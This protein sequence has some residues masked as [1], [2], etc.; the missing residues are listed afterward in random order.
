MQRY[1]LSMVM[2]VGIVLVLAVAILANLGSSQSRAQADDGALLQ[3]PDFPPTPTVPAAPSDNPSLQGASIFSDAFVADGA[4]PAGWQVIDL[5]Q[6]MPGEESV[7]RVAGGRLIQDRTARASNPASRITLAV[8][9]DANLSDYTVSAKAFDLANAT[10]GL[11]ARA[12]GQSFYQFAWYAKDVSE[13]KKLVLEKV[14]DGNSTILAIADGP[15][16]EHRTW[17]TLGLQVSGSSIRALIDGKVV[18]EATD[19]S[20]TN[21]QFGVSTVAFGAVTF[22]NVVVTVP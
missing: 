9:G 3:M 6:I 15:G 7:W 10:I 14:I 2:A 8:N 13:E 1:R 20:L 22:D 4:L 17:Y 16:Y 21:G 19:S 18:L 11:V 5:G 12:Q